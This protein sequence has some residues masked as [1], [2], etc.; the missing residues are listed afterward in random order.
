[1]SSVSLKN[2]QELQNQYG[3]RTVFKFSH[4]EST[5]SETSTKSYL[6][7]CK[8]KY[9]NFVR[10]ITIHEH[11]EPEIWVENIF[12]Q[13]YKCMNFGLGYAQPE[14][15][16]FWQTRSS[17]WS[18][19][20]EHTSMKAKTIDFITSDLF[21][22]DIA[23]KTRT[24]CGNNIIGAFSRNNFRFHV[25]H[26]LE[27]TRSTKPIMLVKMWIPKRLIQFGPIILGSS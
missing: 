3:D 17:R 5:S 13:M 7:M 4:N 6:Y 21:R 15:K 27:D 2:M 23:W 1:M 25:A 18:I 22:R 24:T 14:R 26:I 12:D 10:S 11:K 19:S 20:I 16:A 9:I 8:G